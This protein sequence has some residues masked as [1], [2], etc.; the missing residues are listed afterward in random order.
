MIKTGIFDKLLGKDRTKEGENINF[1]VIASQCYAFLDGTGWSWLGLTG[2][3]DF[4]GGTKEYRFEGNKILF[5][6]AWIGTEDS[7]RLKIDV[8][9][10]PADTKVRTFL[11]ILQ[12]IFGFEELSGI[13]IANKHSY[14]SDLTLAE[15]GATNE[16]ELELSQW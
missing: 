7:R 15:I 4:Q 13:L 14:K 8:R 3:E 1:S 16:S 6:V 5:D 12:R 2:K 11:L 9:N 10:I